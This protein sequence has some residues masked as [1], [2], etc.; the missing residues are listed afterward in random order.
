GGGGSG[1]TG[2]MATGG[3]GGGVRPGCAFGELFCGGCMPS[4]E[5]HC[6]S[7]SN[8]CEQGEVC[9][10]GT[11]L[12]ACTPAFGIAPRELSAT[13]TALAL[14][15]TDGDGLVGL[16]AAGAAV[17]VVGKAEGGLTVRQQVTLTTPAKSVA[18]GDVDGDGDLD[19]VVE[20][21]GKLWFLAADK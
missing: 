11:C 12:K 18:V 21:G 3:T 6:G 19:V 10:S 17:S 14:A 4:D 20:A 2:G 7:C 8:A 16:V 1:G 5:K 9:S 15:D 13:A